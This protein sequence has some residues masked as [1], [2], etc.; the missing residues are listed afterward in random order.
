MICI[1]YIFSKCDFWDSIN[2]IINFAP[3]SNVIKVHFKRCLCT[4]LQLEASVTV[5]PFSSSDYHSTNFWMLIYT[6][7]MSEFLL[8]IHYCQMQIES[9]AWNTAWSGF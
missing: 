4:K 1:N 3:I 5:V 6:T 7:S 2:F 9:S 8:E